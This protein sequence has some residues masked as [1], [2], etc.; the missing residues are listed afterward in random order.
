M[1]A[2]QLGRTHPEQVHRIHQHLLTKA[3]L[4]C[5]T[6]RTRDGASVHTCER[7]DGPPVLMI[8]GSGSPALFWLP[9]LRQLGGVRAIAVDRPGFGLSDPVPTDPDPVASAAWISEVLDG[10]GLPAAVIV[11]HSMGGLW[12]LRF[13]LASPQRARGLVMLGTPALPGT[14]APLAFRLL[15]TPGVRGLI[16]RQRETPASFRRFAA[17]VGEGKTIDR[18]PELV[19]LMVAVGND[20]VAGRA[21]QDEVGRLLS[22]WALLTR[23][24]FRRGAR[25][26]GTDLQE[27]DVPTL[28]MWGS[29][30]PVGDGGVARRIQ[31]LIQGS[32]LVV[33]PGGH[34]PWLG[35][36][37]MLATALLEWASRLD[38]S[39]EPDSQSG[40]GVSA[41][42]QSASG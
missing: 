41:G 21:M 24:G 39:T 28:L 1:N 35:Q 40:G 2:P 17:L 13:A 5:R 38:D 10:L 19:D 20:P 16:A 3:G 22:P 37:R 4:T 9:L 23:T 42:G 7:G 26:S 6:L 31:G 12:A 8:H 34:A 11:G 33:V 27:V 32:E 36:S 14:K 25:V 29:N 15:A 18:H 30:D